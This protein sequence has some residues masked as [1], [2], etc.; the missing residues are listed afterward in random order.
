ML[1][2]TGRPAQARAGGPLAQRVQIPSPAMLAISG[3]A[4]MY[5][6]G[7]TRPCRPRGTLGCDV[8]ATDCHHPARCGLMAA[9]WVAGS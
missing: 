2:K 5:S 6:S 3:S 1:V 9:S 4:S 8:V 7:Y